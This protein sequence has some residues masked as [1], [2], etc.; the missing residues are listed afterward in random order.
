DTAGLRNARSLRLD[1]DNLY[2]AGNGSITR[3]SLDSSDGIPTFAEQIV[4]GD[5]AH[6]TGGEVFGLDDTAALWLPA[7]GGQLYAASGR[8]NA[9]IT[10]QRNVAAEPSLAFA[11]IQIDGL[12]GVAPGEEVFYTIVVHNHG[13]S[14]APE[15]LV[16]DEF[17]DQFENV[18][19]TCTAAHGAQCAGSGEGD[20]NTE[21]A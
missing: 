5:P 2:V 18:S 8:A 11:D 17:P 7:D 12:G 20:I 21:V 1:G 14:A 19:W 13:P 3:F 15:A 4:N 16:V 10:F 9:V 6:L